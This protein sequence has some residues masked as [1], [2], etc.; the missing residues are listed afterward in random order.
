[1]ALNVPSVAATLALSCS[2]TAMTIIRSSAQYKLRSTGA[3]TG[4]HVE[5]TD[6]IMMTSP[7]EPA[8]D[9]TDDVNPDRVTGSFRFAHNPHGASRY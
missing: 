2:T 7:P 6:E 8:D 9:D 4:R 1:M 3:G 5:E